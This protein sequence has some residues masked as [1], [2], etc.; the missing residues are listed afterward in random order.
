MV[1]ALICCFHMFH[2]FVD[3]ERKVYSLSSMPKNVVPLTD[4]LAMSL[5]SKFKL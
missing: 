4:D 2:L 3:P 1:R 5:N